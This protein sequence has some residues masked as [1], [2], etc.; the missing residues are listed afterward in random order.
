MKK[1]LFGILALTAVATAC[2][3]EKIEREKESLTPVTFEKVALEDNFW[4]PRLKTQKETLVPYS[5]GKVEHAVRNLQKVIDYR[6]GKKVEGRF[7]GPY[8]VAS[9]L[10][11]VME[12]AAYL[13]IL[14][15]D[16]K[17]EAQM[18]EIIDVIAAAQDEDGYL[19]ECHM[20]PENLSGGDRWRGGESRYSF[21]VHSHELYNMGH[22][23]EGAIAYY[24]ATGKR[25]WLDVAEKNAQH[26]NR[27]FFEGDPNYNGGKPIMQAP[28][29]EEIELALVKLAQATGNKLY[30]EMAKKFLDVRGVTYCPD[31][32]G[33]MAPTYAQQHQPVREQRTAEGHSVRAMYLYSGMAD[34]VAELG[35]TTLNPALEAI[36]NDVMD[37]KIHINGGLGAV[38][39]IEGFGPEYV[40]PNKDTYDETCAAVG[41]VFFN[42]RMFLASGE[43]KYVD[44]AEVSLYNNVL[45]GVNIEGNK[46]FYVNVLEADGKKAFNHGRAGRSPWFGTACCPSNMARLIPQVSGMVYSHTD[47]DIYTALYAGSSTVVPLAAGDV[48]LK[49]TTAYPFEG[50]VTIDVT[51]AVEGQEFTMWL[52]IP[53]WCGEQF[54]PGKLYSY[55]DNNKSKVVAKVNGERVRTAVVDGYMPVKRAWAA[56]DKVELELSM[57]VRYSV[58]DERVEADLNRVCVTRG[59][60]VYCAE[61]PDNEHPASNYVVSKIGKQGEVANFTEGIMNGISYVTMPAEVVVGD[62]AQNANLTLIPYYAWNNRGDNI[63]MNVWFARDAQTVLD[64][65]PHAVGNVKG[66]KASHTFNTDEVFAVADGK[67]PKSSGDTS[68]PRWTS[69]PQKGQKQWVELELK[70]EQEIESVSVYWYDDKGGVQLPTEWSLEYRTAGEWKT[71]VLYNTDNYN[72]FADQ[73]NMVHPAEPIK[74]DAIRINMTPKADAAVGILEVTV[75]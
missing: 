59:P 18:D 20:L 22:M 37:K 57:P 26:I 36:W 67:Q 74:A 17:L 73:Y 50:K 52:R 49:Q 32:K 42:Y 23:Y 31:G 7:E 43:A 3:P 24:R 58:A 30:S 47:D 11:K 33:V 64:A 12:G 35:D 16:E 13:L 34:V 72:L 44:A 21:V 25:K 40:L 15:K 28:G 27:V 56:G 70:K 69:Y 4:L 14:E 29:H 1:T 10:F 71:W 5:L 66:V 60:L 53:T 46:F 61:Q 45:A 68:I 54:I 8:F 9:D 2:Q 62:Q 75:E 63:T 41:N 51:P 38:P 6:N 65:I 19:Y 39:G 55:A 48:A